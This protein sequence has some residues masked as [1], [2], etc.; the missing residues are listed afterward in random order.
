MYLKHGWVILVLAYAT[1]APAQIANYLGP[2]ILSRGAGDIGAHSGEQVD[3]RLS[4]SVSGFVDN[5]LL[6][7]SVTSDGNLLAYVITIIRISESSRRA[8]SFSLEVV[9]KLSKDAF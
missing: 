7:L 4:G 5:G 9:E 1:T 3:L 8:I 2:G 6:P